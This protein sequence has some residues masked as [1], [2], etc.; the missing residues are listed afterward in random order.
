[1]P[2]LTSTMPSL[3]RIYRR[4]S[5][6]GHLR[7]DGYKESNKATYSPADDVYINDEEED[8]SSSGGICP[9]C[10]FALW[11]VAA[12]IVTVEEAAACES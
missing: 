4:Y 9:D 8:T 3:I 11:M 6:C 10:Q 5:R 2:N 7:H 12:E 1:M